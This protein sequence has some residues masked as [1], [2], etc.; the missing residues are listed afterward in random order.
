MT[1]EATK[2]LYFRCELRRNEAGS[3]HINGHTAKAKTKICY[4]YDMKIL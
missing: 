3:W 1:E 2:K 4:I